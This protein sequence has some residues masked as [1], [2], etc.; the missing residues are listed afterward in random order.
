MKKLLV[1]L[2]AAAIAASAMAETYTLSST[3]GLTPNRKPGQE[4]TLPFMQK[5]TQPKYNTRAEEA[6]MLSMDFTYS[7]SPYGAT[8][9]QNLYGME[10]CQAMV[11]TPEM[12]TQFAGSTVK[13]ICFWTGYNSSKSVTSPINDIKNATVFILEGEFQPNQ[14]GLATDPGET[15]RSQEVELPEEGVQY[16]EV[17]LDEPYVIEANKPITV[18]FSI[19]PPST[20]DMYMIY[21]GVGT[22]DPNG[23]WIGM[24]QDGS[25]SW[26]SY[27]QYLGSLCVAMTIEGTNLPV[28]C[29]DI[30]D[31]ELP[32]YVLQNEPF[33][34]VPYVES[35]SAGEITSLEIECTIGND[36]PQT[37]TFNLD[38]PIFFHQGGGLPIND[39]ICTE[40]GPQ[41]ITVKITKV[42]GNP[43]NSE[44]ATIKATFTCADPNVGYERNILVEEG[45]GTW[46][47]WC[48]SGIVFMD[49]LQET[50][51]EVIKVAVHGSTNGATDPMENSSTKKLLG[52]FSGFPA[53]VVNRSV[54]LW[55][56][57]ATVYTD[58]EAAMESLKKI[59]AEAEITELLTEPLSDRQ[60]MVKAKVRFARDIDNSEGQYGLSFEL[61]E[62]NVGPYLQTNG[63][64]GGRN[65]VM[66]GWETKPSAAETIYNDVLRVLDGGM[67][68][69]RDI[70]PT[71][72]KADVEY[73]YEGRVYSTTIG[74]DKFILVGIVTDNTTGDVVNCKSVVTSKTT[75]VESIN[76]DAEVV[77]EQYYD[78]NGIRV[79][80]PAKGIYVKRAIL[81]DG[82]S[83][84]TKVVKD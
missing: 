64:A 5:L 12:A 75:A 63:Y 9:F 2:C 24:M 59:P 1:G 83:R 54:T 70:F 10:V 8:A 71:E 47:T 49:W 73:S 81:S 17:E 23:S 37:M 62:N 20:D 58:F 60:V 82:S 48:P 72:I 42:N 33:T 22:D 31:I 14:N 41:D 34:V 7:Y 77:A 18:G 78:L 36:Q 66:G 74:S 67:G 11:I 52:L 25:R 55:P 29:M 80:N 79:Q 4:S 26:A 65:G 50:Y 21:D 61:I 51:P 30:Y 53:L 16:I 69:Y 32:K 44:S 45:T 3:S 40:L 56:T 13:A 76:D 39:L 43:N 28:N 84:Y 15:L 68:G 6:D 57:S 46:C 19:V 27:Y 35:L 38:D